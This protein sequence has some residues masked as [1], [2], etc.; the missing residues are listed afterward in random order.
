VPTDYDTERSREL[1]SEESEARYL[2]SEAGQ[3]GLALHRSP[4]ELVLLFRV[5]RYYHS[6]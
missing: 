1:S 5:L 3:S 2:I 6:I 4:F